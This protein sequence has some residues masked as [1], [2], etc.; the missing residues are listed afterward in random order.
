M[1]QLGHKVIKLWVIYNNNVVIVD[2][3]I[4]AMGKRISCKIKTKQEIQYVAPIHFLT[5]TMN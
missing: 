2:L 5:Q 3:V 1:S 4:N